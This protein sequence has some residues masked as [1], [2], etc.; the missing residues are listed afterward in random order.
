MARD[1]LVLGPDRPNQKATTTPTTLGKS[2]QTSIQS[3]ISPKS[4]L[5]EPLCLASGLE[6][7]LSEAFLESMTNTIEEPQG[8]SS[9][10]V[11]NQG[12]PFLK[13]VQ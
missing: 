5:S 11:Y 6:T 7:K 10:R 12:G 9:R 4:I 13:H 3:E 8:L 1:E 2:P